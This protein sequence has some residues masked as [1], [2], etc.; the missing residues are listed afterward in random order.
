MSNIYHQVYLKNKNLPW[1]ILIHGL[2]GSHENLNALRRGLSENYNVLS[3]DLPDHGKSQRTET[4]SF[5]HYAELI[6]NFLTALDIKQPHIVAH[7]LGGK[8]AMQMALDYPG[9]ITSLVVM[10]IAPIAYAPRH[11][12]VIN[13]LTHVPLT[14]I[15]SRKQAETFLTEFIDESTT[16]QFL[17][18]SLIETEAG[19]QWLFNLPLIERDYA[20]LSDAIKSEST[21]DG[22]LLFI[23][24]EKSDYITTEA[25]PLILQYFPN[26]QLK[27]IGG[28]GHWLH[29][30]K[31]S[32]CIKM[33]AQFLASQTK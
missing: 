14:S 8:V 7:S 26:S 32:L 15:T 17:L 33:I 22:P 12:A 2:F 3:L 16:R 10:D 11:Q 25:K 27:I 23:K 21:F 24:G 5:S 30:E 31:P 1:I 20:V 6:H 13:G 4:F 19:W 9:S 18:K 29:A 28:V